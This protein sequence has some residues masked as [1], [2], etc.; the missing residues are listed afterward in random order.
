MNSMTAV[1][2]PDDADSGERARTPPPAFLSMVAEAGIVLDAGELERLGSFAAMLLDVNQRINLT[3]VRSPEELWTRHIFDALTLIQVL[4]EVESPLRLLDIGSGGGLP[5]IPLAI[6][7]PSD[8]FTL[9]EATGKKCD[10]LSLTAERLGLDNV[11]VLQGRAE[12]FGQIDDEHGLRSTF[13]VVTSRAVGR[14]AMAS[15]LC[16]PFAKVGGLIVLVK[17]GKAPEELT[18]AKAALHMLHLAS[19]GLIPTPTGTLVVLEKLRETPAK[20][21]RAVGEPK[22]APLG[23]SKSAPGGPSSSRR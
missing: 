17:G 21:P 10:F 16:A 6:V 20:Y 1:E 19:A 5:A 4:E 9:L 23:V 7:R 2:T 13:N 12:Q 15:E 3:G 8:R 18:E 14:V 22:R 11:T